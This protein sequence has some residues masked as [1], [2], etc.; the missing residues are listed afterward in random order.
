M[1]VTFSQPTLAADRRTMSVHIEVTSPS[2]IRAISILDRT[3]QLA[4]GQFDSGARIELKGCPT[5]WSRT[6]SLIRLDIF[7]IRVEVA[8]CGKGQPEL[9][10]P[11]GLPSMSEP[12]PAPDCRDGDT[13]PAQRRPPSIACMEANADATIA[14]ETANHACAALTALTQ[15]QQEWRREYTWFRNAWLGASAVAVG[16][17]FVP[18]VGPPAALVASAAALVFLVAAIRAAIQASHLNGQVVEAQHRW[19]LARARYGEAAVRVVQACC[20]WDRSPIDL[21]L[22]CHHPQPWA[23]SLATGRI[24]EPGG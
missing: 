22:S 7:P 1:T 6:L 24:G 3:G 18:F 20:P 16:L 5:E 19:D 21:N 12:P 13:N 23:G 17:V 15:R 9:S 8:S 4:S 10:E 11:L 2:G 14:R